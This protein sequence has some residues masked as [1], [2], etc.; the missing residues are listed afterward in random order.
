MAGSGNIERDDFAVIASTRSDD[1]VALFWNVRDFKS[2]VRE[3]GPRDF[4]AQCFFSVYIFKNLQGGTV[5]AMTR[6]S[7]MP[8]PRVRAPASCQSFEL[9][10]V[11]IPLAAD[12][13]AI[14]N[15][16]VKLRQAL[17]VAGNEIGVG[18]SNM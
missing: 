8:S 13:N 16:F 6:Q 15:P 11:V 7:Q 18:V 14:E 5:L 9:G 1:F 10:S 2:D 4:R 12:G 17:P 3:T